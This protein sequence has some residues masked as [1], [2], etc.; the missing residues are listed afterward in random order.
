MVT[1]YIIG[2]VVLVGVVGIYYYNKLVRL[3]NQVENSWSQI[4]VQLKRRNDLIP[5]LVETVKGYTDHEKTV[6]NDVTEARSKLDE[7]S[8]PKENAEANAMMSSALGRLFAVA[9]DYPDLKAN[10]N[11]LELQEELSST[12]N[13]IA[14]ARQNYN[15]MV[16]KYNTAIESIPTNIIAGMGSFEQRELFDIPEEERDVPEVSF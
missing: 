5:N 1:A 13:K 10:E 12:E 4:D 14:Y 2:G 9:E 3:D 15:D 6:F 7:A 11:Y 16:M 8:S